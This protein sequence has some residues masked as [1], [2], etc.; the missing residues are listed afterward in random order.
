[1]AGVY[2]L[3]IPCDLASLA[4]VPLRFAKGTGFR[5][6]IG[7]RGRPGWSSPCPLLKEGVFWVSRLRGDD[8]EVGDVEVGGLGWW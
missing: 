2:A 7:V 8:D 3:G 1:M 5:P 6:R 4:R